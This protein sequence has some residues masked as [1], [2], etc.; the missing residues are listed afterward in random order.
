MQ[1]PTYITHWQTDAVACTFSPRYQIAVD[2]VTDLPIS[3]GYTVVLTVIDRFSNGVRFIPFT[4][5]PNA[6]QMAECLFNLVFRLFGI[7]ENIVSDRGTQFTSQVWRVFM[8]RLGI[9]VSLTSGYHPQS[10]GQCERAKQELGKFLR[11]YCHNNQHE[12]HRY[13]P[14]AEIAQNSLISLTTKITPFQCMYGYQP[15]LMPWTA[16]PSE[17]PAVESWM[18]CREQVWEETHQWIKADQRHGDT[19]SYSIGDQV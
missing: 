16:N 11:L 4:Q 9:T 6:L 5:L 12:R 19:S 14:W 15:P 7:P 8:E 3:D 1:N 10:N 17:V 13:L 18:S 2:F